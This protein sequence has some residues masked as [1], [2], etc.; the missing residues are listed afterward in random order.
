M[1]DKNIT[2]FL[3]EGEITV[4]VVD[5]N[6]ALWF[7]AADVCR[8][9]G[10]TN[11]AETVRHLEEDERGISTTDTSVGPREVVVVSESGLYALIFKSR[12]PSAIHFRKWVTSVVLPALRTAGHYHLPQ[13]ATPCAQPETNKVRMVAEARQVFGA[14]AAGELWFALSLPVVAAMRL[15]PAQSDLFMT[16]VPP[17]QMPAPMA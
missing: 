5:R 15:A 10:L 2:P 12:K 11:P 9:L 7:V 3:F 14:R 4:R 13:A 16:W 6:G 17:G 1:T 8:A